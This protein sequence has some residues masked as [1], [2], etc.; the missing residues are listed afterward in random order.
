MKVSYRFYNKLRDLRSRAAAVPISLP[1]VAVMFAG[2]GVLASCA[3]ANTSNY[4]G[5]H[6]ESDDWVGTCPAQFE[7]GTLAGG[8]VDATLTVMCNHQPTVEETMT[9]PFVLGTGHY[10]AV[11]TAIKTASGFSYDQDKNFDLNLAADGC[12][13][14]GTVTDGD[15]SSHISFDSIAQDCP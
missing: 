8:M 11:V 13:M 7:V 4:A 14:S 2:F 9:G 15:S 3:D 12:T 6:G 1:M 10:R 5:F